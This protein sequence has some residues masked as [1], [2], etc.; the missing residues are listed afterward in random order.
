MRA[1]AASQATWQRIKRPATWGAVL[2]F[3]LVW[4]MARWAMG[5]P[6]RTPEDVAGPFLW[7]LLFL[8]I[9]PLPW[10]WTGDDASLA[11]PWRGILQAIPWNAAWVL[12][13][14]LLLSGGGPRPGMGRGPGMMGRGMRMMAPP[15][16]RP[17]LP[18][19]PRLLLLAVTNLSVCVLLGWILADK[20]RAEA[21]AREARRTAAQA[22]ARALQAQMNPHVLF[23]ALSGL[24]ELVREDAEAAEQALV[25]LADLL[26]DLLEHGARTAAPLARERALVER[27]LALE[28]IRLGRRLQVDWRWDRDLEGV[29]APPLLLQP[30][31]EN[32]LKHGIAPSRTGGEVCIGLRAGG[33]D[34]ELEVAN[35]GLPLQED[36]PEGVGVR[37]LRERLA[38]LGLPA[39]AFSLSRDGDWTRARILLPWPEAR[40]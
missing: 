8:A 18:L 15:Q 40:P 31:V 5:F 10:Q 7:A 36:A 26:R 25:S 32:A 24:T 12:A 16:D 6:S 37:N 39:S 11:R 19:H 3:G 13:L 1:L 9:T 33:T 38:L 20:E 30:L 22:Q 17:W 29:E 28:Q 14:L 4:T 23:N 21:V 34:L 27:Y 35:T 2:L